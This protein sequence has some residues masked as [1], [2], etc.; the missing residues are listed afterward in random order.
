MRHQILNAWPLVKSLM[1]QRN[2]YFAQKMSAHSWESSYGRIVICVDHPFSHLLLFNRSV[3]AFIVKTHKTK[4][5]LY[6]NVSIFAGAVGLSHNVFLGLELKHIQLDSLGYI[7]TR[8]V[9]T[10]AHFNTQSTLFGNT[11][12]FFTGNYKEVRWPVCLLKI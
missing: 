11:L 8:H 4:K 10:C 2:V 3:A 9:S 1:S 7:L 12:K 5:N 6:T